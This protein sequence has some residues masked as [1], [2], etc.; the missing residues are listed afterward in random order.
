MPRVKS[1][2]VP[3]DTYYDSVREIL[4]STLEALQA[5]YGEVSLISDKN[6]SLQSYVSYGSSPSRLASIS[7]AHWVV[8]QGEPLAL[9]NREQT[10]LVPDLV[11][12][13]SEALPLDCVPI[14]VNGTTLGALQSNFPSVAG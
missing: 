1:V 5:K 6:G 11:I 3:S 4:H 10:L 13:K 2:G 8:I 7:V 14:Q 12:S 9:E